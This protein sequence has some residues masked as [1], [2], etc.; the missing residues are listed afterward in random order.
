MI[1]TYY[2]DV[3]EAGIF[4]LHIWGFFSFIPNFKDARLYN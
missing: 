1:M 4:L 2:Q 3:L